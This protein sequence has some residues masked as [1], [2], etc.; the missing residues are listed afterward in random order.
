MRG[1]LWRTAI[2]MLI[3]VVA[4]IIILQLFSSAFA[5]G[6]N[7]FG[8]AFDWFEDKTGVQIGPENPSAYSIATR[9]Q[10]GGVEFT[11]DLASNR[12]HDILV[13]LYRSGDEVSVIRIGPDEEENTRTAFL[14]LDGAIA[15]YMEVVVE[16]ESSPGITE[17]IMSDRYIVVE[18]A[19][20]ETGTAGSNAYSVLRGVMDSSEVNLAKSDLQSSYSARV[21]VVFAAIQ[22]SCNVPLSCGDYTA[23]QARGPYTRAGAQAFVIDAVTECA[24]ESSD[25]CKVAIASFANWMYCLY[26]VGGPSFTNN[27]AL[28]ERSL[29]ADIGSGCTVQ[30]SAS[31]DDEWPS[32]VCFSSSEPLTRTISCDSEM[33]I[34]KL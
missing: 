5:Q 14:S 9:E 23:T 2:D 26:P 22:S 10:S 4:I 30:E 11:I 7:V 20:I 1:I 17:N 25:A 33:V 13:R 31:V 16:R 15:S 3:V 29:A 12:E 28:I 32:S 27:M 19:R 21:N 24:D 18:P 6:N 34:L 8:G